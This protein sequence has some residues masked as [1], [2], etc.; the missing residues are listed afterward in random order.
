[1][2]KRIQSKTPSTQPTA[3]LVPTATEETTLVPITSTEEEQF[4]EPQEKVFEVTHDEEA[5]T[6]SF[7]LVDGT[8]VVIRSPKPKDFLL[9]SS[10]IKQ[11]EPEYTSEEMILI[12][13]M[14]LCITKFGSATKIDFH[15][16][17]DNLEDLEDLERLG[18]AFA[19]FRSAIERITSRIKK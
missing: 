2:P 16:F 12:K 11:A 5:G 19:F 1:M 13:L 9:I 14:T 6:V 7:S 18:K 15:Q 3:A 8:P 10:F 17:L 4:Q